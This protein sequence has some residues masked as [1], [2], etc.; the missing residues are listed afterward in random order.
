[1][2]PTIPM[3]GHIIRAEQVS[4][5]MYVSIDMVV[6]I[7]ERQ[8]NYL[9]AAIHMPRDVI[10]DAFFKAG[11]YK[12]RPTGPIEFKGF[13]RKWI[14]E[15]APQFGMNFNP[16]KYRLKDLNVICDPE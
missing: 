16:V 7:I 2:S 13:M 14:A 15:I 10:T 6:E 9:G 3:K 1:M 12:H 8:A 4:D 11:R 5:D